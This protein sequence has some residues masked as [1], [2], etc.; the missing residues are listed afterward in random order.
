MTVKFMLFLW[1][2][3]TFWRGGFWAADEK[4]WWFHSE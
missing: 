2:E 4:E 1:E 3:L